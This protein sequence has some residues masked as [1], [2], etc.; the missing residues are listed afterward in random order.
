MRDSGA[1]IR[2]DIWQQ[3]E[4]LDIQ[5]YQNTVAKRNGIWNRNP[6]WDQ[7]RYKDLDAPPEEADGGWNFPSHKSDFVTFTTAS[8]D[9]D[10][11][12]NSG[13]EE[14]EDE[15]EDDGDFGSRGRG[16]D[17]RWQWRTETTDSR[18]TGDLR[19]KLDS[20]RRDKW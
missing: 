17:R 16:K 5:Q 18:S 7:N 12:K 8:A 15:D 14:E 9:N 3:D 1:R 6:D 11:N 19:K 20:R 10:F 2:S 4:E 13:N